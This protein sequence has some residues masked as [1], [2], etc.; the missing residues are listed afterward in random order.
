[1]YITPKTAKQTLQ[2]DTRFNKMNE[3]YVHVHI[4]HI[5]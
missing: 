3:L 4:D 2:H 1:M 5:H